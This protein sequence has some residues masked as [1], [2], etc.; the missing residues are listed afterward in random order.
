MTSQTEICIRS[1]HCI[2]LVFQFKQRSAVEAEH[3]AAGSFGQSTTNLSQP[4]P[5][6]TMTHREAEEQ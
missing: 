5:Y 4:T 3:K 1:F 2:C 6:R